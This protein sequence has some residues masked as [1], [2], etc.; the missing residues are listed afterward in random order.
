MHSIFRSTTKYHVPLTATTSTVRYASGSSS[1]RW[2]ARNLRDPYSKS[3][4]T[5]Y[6]SRSAFKLEEI[7][8]KCFRF[9]DEGDMHTV[10]DLGAAPGGWSQVVSNALGWSVSDVAGEAN[11]TFDPLR[12][13]E[14]T[15]ENSGRGKII[16]VDLLPVQPIHGVHFIQGNFHHTNTDAL[17][18]Q[19]LHSENNP[20]GKADVVLSDMATNVTGNAAHD[21]QSSLTICESVFDFVCRHLR[22]ASEKGRKH[23]GVVV[24]KYFEHPELN[25]FCREKLDPNFNAVYRIKPKSSRAESS[26]TYFVCMGWR[27]PPASCV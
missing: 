19:A 7:N 14:H 22:T 24:M 27:D 21:S 23:G 3:R 13:D 1:K 12:L 6:R 4:S 17:I 15:N 11:H 25:R 5:N 16:S 2:I 9:L 20:D 18:R 26:E 10:V 8:Q